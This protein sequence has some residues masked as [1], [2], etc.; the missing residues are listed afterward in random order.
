MSIN[1]VCGTLSN[2]YFINIVLT[3]W[4]NK[5]THKKIEIR[6]KKLLHGGH[7]TVQQT[8]WTLDNSRKCSSLD[9]LN[10][11]LLGIEKPCEFHVVRLYAHAAVSR[12]EKTFTALPC[13][14]ADNL[15]F[16]LYFYYQG[17]ARLIH[18]SLEH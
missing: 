15:H 16:H 8:P 4:S 10:L 9:V 11:V 18:F 13:E 5:I 12:C 2:L 7:V 14:F 6:Q 1:G 17:R 3:L